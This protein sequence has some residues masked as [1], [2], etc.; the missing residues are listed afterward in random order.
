VFRTA[1]RLARPAA[2]LMAAVVAAACVST[3]GAAPSGTPSDKPIDPDQVVF[4]VSWEGGFVTP[5]SLLGRL[6]MIVVYADGRVITQ[7]PQIL[8]YP[9]PLMPNLQE[10]TLSQ[11]ALDRL[12]ELARDKD[13]LKTIHYEFPSIADAAD[14]VLEINIDGQSYRVSAYAL[15]EAVDLEVPSGDV[16]LDPA[17]IDGRAALREFIDSLITIP[18]SDFVDEEHPLDLTAVRIYAAKAVIVPNSELPGEQPAIDWPLEDL[19]TAGAA[20]ENSPLDVRCQVIEGDD[21]AAVLPLLQAANSLQTFASEG[22]LYSFTVRPL[23]P[24]ETGC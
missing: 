22:E 1:L 19:A 24:G 17:A 5:E 11:A 13:L 2:L 18:A 3:A 8:I 7:G 4:R 23:L 20:V 10:H 12:I 21:L 9:G 15:A 6:P 16:V 14:T